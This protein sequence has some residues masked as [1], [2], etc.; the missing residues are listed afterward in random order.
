MLDLG[1]DG[2]GPETRSSI[3][4]IK[5]GW[6]SNASYEKYIYYPCHCI[7]YPGCLFIRRPDGI[8]ASPRHTF[9]P[10]DSNGE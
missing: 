6:N 4:R 8:R 5:I 2:R 9:S 3:L 7:G 1:E 10:A